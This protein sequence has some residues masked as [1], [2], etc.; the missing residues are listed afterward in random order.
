MLG[1]YQKVTKISGE[2][3]WTPSARCI[4]RSLQRYLKARPPSTYLV[5]LLSDIDQQKIICVA[6]FP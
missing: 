3:N 1:K 4:A 2:L 5:A 6:D